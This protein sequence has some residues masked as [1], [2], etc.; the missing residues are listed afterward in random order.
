MTGQTSSAFLRQLSVGHASGLQL[1]PYRLPWNQ[2]VVIIG[3]EASCQV[4]LDS[5]SYAGVSRRHAAV[6][7]APG[8]CQ[9]CDL[10]SSNGTYINGQRLYGCQTLQAGDRI[11]L[12]QN[13]A[14][15]IFEY[16][17]AYDT[18]QSAPPRT[19]FALFKT[20][21]RIIVTG[22]FAYG[23]VKVLGPLLPL[24][25]TIWFWRG[26]VF[27]SD[28]QRKEIA[29]RI[30]GGIFAVEL[31]LSFWLC[32]K[33][34]LRTELLYQLALVIQPLRKFESGILLEPECHLF[35]LR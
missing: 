14:E 13:S 20:A 28:L 29:L 34:F 19:G 4:I 18:N 31:V 21:L 32:C 17:N 6:W 8:L 3:R 5:N 25:L 30:S 15:F 22:A 9:I 1:S 11:L 16:Q 23:L 10:N 35:R 24:L 26:N 27:S 12:G 7:L 33:N 2:E